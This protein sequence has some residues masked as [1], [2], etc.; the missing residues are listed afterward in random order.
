MYNQPFIE[1]YFT[2]I[3][4]F[5][6]KIFLFKV[7]YYLN[8]KKKKAIRGENVIKLHYTYTEPRKCSILEITITNI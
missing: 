5:F 2:V 4:F 8:F 7:F 1:L 6:F 3:F